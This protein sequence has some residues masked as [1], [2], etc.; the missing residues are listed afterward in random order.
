MCR[1]AY[2]SHVGTWLGGLEGGL[3]AVGFGQRER[4]RVGDVCVG[5]GRRRGVLSA[6]QSLPLVAVC[7]LPAHT[8]AGQRFNIDA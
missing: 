5:A 6:R 4:V 2:V 3:R 1:F 7:Q 8:H